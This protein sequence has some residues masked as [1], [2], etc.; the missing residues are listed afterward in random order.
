MVT[1]QNPKDKKW[2]TYNE[3]IMNVSESFRRD[4]LHMETKKTLTRIELNTKRKAFSL[5]SS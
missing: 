1:K 2:K 4:R 3:K 5:S